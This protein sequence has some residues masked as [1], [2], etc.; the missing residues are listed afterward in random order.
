M[1]RGVS[2]EPDGS[3]PRPGTFRWTAISHESLARQ[4]VPIDACARQAIRAA[5]PRSAS[6]TTS[7]SSP[8]RRAFDFVP[9]DVRERTVRR[10]RALGPTGR[11]DPVR[12]RDHVRL[13]AREAIRDHSAASLRLRHRQRHVYADSPYHAAGGGLGRDGHS[14]RSWPRIS[15]RSSRRSGQALMGA[16]GLDFVKRYLVPHASRD[17]AQAPELYS[18]SCV[19]SSMRHGARGEHERPPPGSPRD[20]SNDAVVARFQVLGG[21]AVS[22]GSDAHDDR[23]FSSGLEA[24]YR[25]VATAGI[26]ADVP[27]RRG[28]GRRGPS[29]RFRQPARPTRR[30]P[31]V[32]DHRR[33][34]D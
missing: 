24:G 30:R 3:R 15:M 8:A 25:V 5:L 1:V 20:L 23:A 16:I 18:R 28:Q 17:L 31:V 29:D 19:R 34:R 11:R 13:A 21:T 9:F 4:P 32:I 6:P 10:R 2:D 7:T 26:N 12:R 22:A 27:S 33:R 14:T